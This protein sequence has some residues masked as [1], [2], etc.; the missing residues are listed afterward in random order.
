MAGRLGTALCAT[1]LASALLGPARTATAAPPAGGLS[2]SP[3]LQEVVIPQGQ[4]GAIPF[5]IAN[6]SDTPITVRFELADLGPHRQL[7]P[8]GESP[9]SL[10][11]VLSLPQGAIPLPPKARSTVTA[12]VTGDGRPHM[13]AIIIQA[14]ASPSSPAPFARI[15]STLIVAPPGPVTP[16]DVSLKADPSGRLTLTIANPGPRLIHAWGAV[17]LIAPDGALHG[18]IDVPSIYV[19]PGESSTIA[20]AW[21]KPLPAGTTARAALQIQGSDTLSTASARVP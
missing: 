5:T 6:P 15:L 8:P 2:A 13:G 20:L 19:I 21:P 7:L 12:T 3:T 14:F 1:A 4:S 11:P 9:E 16:P 18:K 10:S 17:F